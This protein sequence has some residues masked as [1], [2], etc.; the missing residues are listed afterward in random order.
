MSIEF[1]RLIPRGMSGIG[2]IDGLM[3]KRNLAEDF[4]I[5]IFGGAQPEWQYGKPQTKLQK[6]G[7]FVSGGLSRN[8]TRL[9][10]TVALAAEYHYRTVSREFIHLRNLIRNKGFSFYQSADLDINRSWRGDRTKESLALTNF[11]VSA[12]QRFGRITAGVS[13]DTRKRYR[14]YDTRTVADSLFD[15]LARRGLKATMNLKAPA[16]IN[17]GTSYGMRTREGESHTSNSYSLRVSK[18]NFTRLGIRLDFQLTGF[19]NR[20]S[21]G[22]KL[23]YGGSRYFRNGHRLSIGYGVYR[24]MYKS[25]EESRSSRWFEG[26]LSFRLSRTLIFSGDFKRSVGDDINGLTVLADIAYIFR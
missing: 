18:G 6:Y 5:G 12:R 17:V 15:D 11:Y 16:G 8:D 13:Y 25:I 14:D 20:Y 2:Y 9:E 4:S 19:S 3:V 1:G 22:L 24:Y 23:S 10:S 26:G 21:D 7:L